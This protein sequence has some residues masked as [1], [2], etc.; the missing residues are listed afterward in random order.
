MPYE[1]IMK[2]YATICD[3][4]ISFSSS[5]PSVRSGWVIYV[6]CKFWSVN[7]PSTPFA[8]FHPLQSWKITWQWSG[9]KRL[10]FPS[11][12]WQSHTQTR[13]AKGVE[14][15][16]ELRSK[17]DSV[18]CQVLFIFSAQPRADARASLIFIHLIDRIIF[19]CWFN[20]FFALLQCKSS[21]IASLEIGAIFLSRD[22]PRFLEG[23]S[24]GE[25]EIRRV[26]WEMCASSMTTWRFTSR[27]ETLITLDWVL[28]FGAATWI[29]VSVSIARICTCVNMETETT[30]L[31]EW[32]KIKCE[33]TSERE[34]ERE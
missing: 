26:T 8:F 18:I 32:H 24:G 13:I 34:R 33:R 14:R 20:F 12:N 11:L 9:C 7:F 19:C 3:A 1:P 27:I 30:K 15:A 10:L 21:Q 5:V 22:A 28:E 25:R 2:F 6:T 29:A 4:F 23:A 31:N 16:R 17:Q